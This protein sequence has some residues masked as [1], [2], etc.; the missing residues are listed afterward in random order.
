MFPAVTTPQQPMIC[1]RDATLERWLRFTNVR[2]IVHCDRAS[3]VTDCLREV[4]D[5]VARGYSAAGFV[6]Y[7][8]SAA[9][10]GDDQSAE[11]ALPLVWFAIC[12]AVETVDAP[13]GVTDWPSLL[14]R[15]DCCVDAYKEQL[16]RIRQAIADGETYQVNFTYGLQAATSPGFDPWAF[17]PT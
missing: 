6:S 1:L 12:D 4:D 17:F 11:T 7:E 5:Y 15:S 8:A 13:K 3:E 10:Y 9:F 14:W 2:H 16:A